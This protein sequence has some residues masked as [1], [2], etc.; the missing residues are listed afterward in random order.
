MR[1]TTP[2]DQAVQSA[3][4]RDVSAECPDPGPWRRADVRLRGQLAD[5]HGLTDKFHSSDRPDARHIHDQ[6][7]PWRNQPQAQAR[8]RFPRRMRSHTGRRVIRRA[9]SAVGPGLACLTAS[10]HLRQRQR[11]M[12][13]PASMRLRGIAASTGCTA[14]VAVTTD[15]GWFCGWCGRKDACFGLNCEHEN[16]RCRCALVISGQGEQTSSASQP[17]ASFAA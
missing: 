15:V 5:R 8:F 3:G 16:S 12:A 2:A 1:A 13:L 4:Q 10:F 11:L 17:P 14:A 6:K 7:N 9:A